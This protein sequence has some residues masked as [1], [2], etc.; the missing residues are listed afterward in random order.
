MCEF[1]NL[2]LKGMNICIDKEKEGC[3]CSAAKEHFMD[4]LRDCNECQ[5]EG[6]CEHCLCKKALDKVHKGDSVGSSLMEV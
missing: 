4:M 2:A 6:G 3:D 1:F 5:C